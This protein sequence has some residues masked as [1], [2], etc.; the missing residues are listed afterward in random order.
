MDSQ[1]P[2]FPLST[3]SVFVLPAPFFPNL[4]KEQGRTDSLYN[5]N[6]PDAGQGQAK[7]KDAQ[8]RNWQTEQPKGRDPNSQNCTVTTG[9]Q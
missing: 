2:V 8:R 6:H 1:Y 5:L 4:Q 7:S 3:L 9:T